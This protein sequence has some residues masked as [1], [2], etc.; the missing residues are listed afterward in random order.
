MSSIFDQPILFQHPRTVLLRCGSDP[1]FHS[2]RC[3]PKAKVVP[4]SLW[5]VKYIVQESGP[6]ARRRYLHRRENSRDYFPFNTVSRRGSNRSP[7]DLLLGGRF[8]HSSLGRRLAPSPLLYIRLD[9]DRI[10]AQSW[11]N[12]PTTPG[13]RKHICSHFLPRS[14]TGSP[15]L[16]RS[17]GCFMMGRRHPDGQVY[18]KQWLEVCGLAA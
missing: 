12:R 14:A 2:L 3:F 16:F 1:P 15:F 6:V 5:G 8:L 18:T 7:L 9:Y 13:H 17:W 4:C 11:I 10:H